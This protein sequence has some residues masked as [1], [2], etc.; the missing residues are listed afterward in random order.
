MVNDVWEIGGAYESFMGRWSRLVAVEFLQWLS[1]PAGSSWLDVGCGT[2]IL[3]QAILE[4]ANPGKVRGI[5]QAPGLISFAKEHVRDPRAT[6]DVELADAHMSGRD[7]YDAVVSGL[8][9]NFIPN[10]DQAVSEMR[11]A[12]NHGGVVAAYVWDYAGRM[13]LLRYFWDA[14]VVLDSHAA[15]LDEGRRFPLCSP[16]ILR[17]LFIG[18]GL[19]SVDVESIDIQTHFGDFQDFWTPFLSGQGPAPSYVA[20][21]NAEQ[22]SLLRELIRSAL[23]VSAQGAIDL[24]ARAWAVRG[25]S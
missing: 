16:E 24:M 12:T 1:V 6:F 23:P 25:Y 5:D 18:Q 15:A 7:T 9:L 13:Q 11:R 20:T 3:S 8:V 21:L 19:K 2:G 17:D 10:A 22:Q 4:S 14:A